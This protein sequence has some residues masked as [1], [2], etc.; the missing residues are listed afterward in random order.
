MGIKMD[1]QNT[2]NG[3]YMSSLDSATLARIDERTNAQTTS[4]TAHVKD[5]A[6]KFDRVFNFMSKR[7]DKIDE[8]FDKMD[9][10]FEA[11]N[12]KIDNN[13]DL[14]N[15]KVEPL[16]NESNQ[17]KGAFNASRLISASAWAVVVL[18]ANYFM[19]GHK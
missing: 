15:K 18:A 6:E 14:I 16:Q 11:T 2:M 3:K 17:R 5:D 8:R 12:I 4:F 13:S 7:F 9:S 10:K 19:T 1:E